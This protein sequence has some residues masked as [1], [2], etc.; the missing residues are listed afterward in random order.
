M[1]LRRDNPVDMVFHLAIDAWLR[2]GALQPGT[3]PIH[4]Q[5]ELPG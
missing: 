2:K 1:K 5:Q 4:T 3:L